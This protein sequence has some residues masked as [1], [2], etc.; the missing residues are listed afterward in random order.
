[1]WS[2][3]LLTGLL[4][5]WRGTTVS[6][7]M[8]QSCLRSMVF[9]YFEINKISSRNFALRAFQFLGYF[10][11]LWCQSERLSRRS[12]IVRRFLGYQLQNR[13]RNSKVIE[14]LLKKHR[15]TF[16]PLV[17][18]RFDWSIAEYNLLTLPSSS[19]HLNVSPSM[20]SVENRRLQWSLVLWCACLT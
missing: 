3:W 20:K 18:V 19:D 4:E 6:R 13:S 5:L 16:F 15:D 7:I 12:Q 10:S 17:I 9:Y 8:V 1:M 11:F 14:F 2:V